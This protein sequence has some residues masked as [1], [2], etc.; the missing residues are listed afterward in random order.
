VLDPIYFKLKVD[1]NE[2]FGDFPELKDCADE[3]VKYKLL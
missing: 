3:M 2:C 1:L